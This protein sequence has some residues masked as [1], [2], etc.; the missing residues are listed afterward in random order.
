MDKTMIVGSSE[1]REWKR[2]EVAKVIGDEIEA[3]SD[4]C[5]FSTDQVH[6]LRNM[7]LGIQR[8]IE[9]AI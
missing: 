1:H 8:A 9:K 2:S 7:I 5:V 6:A 3:I 4:E